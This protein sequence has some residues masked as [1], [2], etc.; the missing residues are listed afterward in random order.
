[1]LKAVIFDMDGVLI[2]SNPFIRATWEG[3]LH[4]R[5]IILDDEL[6][7]GAVSGKTGPD[8]LRVLF[9]D[10]LQEEEVLTLVD[11]LNRAYRDNIRKQSVLL[12]LPGIPDFIGSLRKSGITIALATSA[13][14]E[15]IELVLGRL[16]LTGFFDHIV[17]DTRVT[18][19]KPDPEIYRLASAETG[20][21]MDQTVV[22]EDSRSGILSARGA[23]LTVIGVASTHTPGEL[24]DL[25]AV[26]V[27]SDFT[28]L[29]LQELHNLLNT[30]K[31]DEKK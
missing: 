19:G 6:F 23:G 7:A 26:M 11:Q 2:D 14:P 10:S 22:F 16:G 24:L 18:R 15:T 30:I 5:G 20:V 1:M 29:S 12:P 21:R 8:T 25:G 13:P 31:P 3:F 17:D 27:I 28:S 9:N 4:S